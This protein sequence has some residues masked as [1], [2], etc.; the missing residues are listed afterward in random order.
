MIFVYRL[1]PNFVRQ[2]YFK[3]ITQPASELATALLSL[4]C[5][6]I[7]INMSLWRSHD[8]LS[9]LQIIICVF[10]MFWLCDVKE[11]VY[12][13]VAMK[14]ELF[15]LPCWLCVGWKLKRECQIVSRNEALVLKVAYVEYLIIFLD[16]CVILLWCYLNW[17]E[18]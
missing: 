1:M 10:D 14:N 7:K 17:L 12:L 4:W 18:N 6:Y 8:V 11:F 15:W 5:C 3:K 9:N 2:T 13:F 16:I